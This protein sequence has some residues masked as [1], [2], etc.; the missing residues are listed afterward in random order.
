MMTLAGAKLGE[1]IVCET[2]ARTV[3]SC[4]VV[5]TISLPFHAFA[6]RIGPQLLVSRF[7]GQVAHQR[8]QAG[9]DDL[10]LS[11]IRSVYTL[12]V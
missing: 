1:L 7:I 5:P 2:L 9:F 4:N 3:G 8:R 10:C 12:R 6:L 11:H